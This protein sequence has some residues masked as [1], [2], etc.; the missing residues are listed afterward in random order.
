[1]YRG[2]ARTVP[3]TYEKF[4]C[5]TLTFVKTKREPGLQGDP[6]LRHPWAHV[7]C[8]S[9]SGWWIYKRGTPHSCNN[10]TA[11]RGIG[12]GDRCTDQGR[13]ATSRLLIW[14]RPRRAVY[15]REIEINTPGYN[16]D[17]GARQTGWFGGRFIRWSP[18]VMHIRCF[19]S[20]AS[21][22]LVERER[23]YGGVTP[24]RVMYSI[25]RLISKWRGQ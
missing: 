9:S 24:L 22:H 16:D 7:W 15:V 2:C 3:S 6:N 23:E 10:L 8:Q 17:V 21:A 19:I 14:K 20:V 18:V 11:L 4:L 13:V 25:T 5:I 1:M 12:R